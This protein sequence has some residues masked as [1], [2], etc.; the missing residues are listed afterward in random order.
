MKKKLFLISTILVMIGGVL[1]CGAKESNVQQTEVAIEETATTEENTAENNTENE[2]VNEDKKDENADVAQE[3]ENEEPVIEETEVPAPTKYMSKEGIVD[4]E[5]GVIIKKDST[6]W[7]EIGFHGETQFE[8]GDIIDHVYF[9]CF[10]YNGDI[11]SYISEHEGLKKGM[12]DNIE[13]AAPD[14]SYDGFPNITFV[15]NGIVLNFHMT[16][17]TVKKIWKKGL[18]ICEKENEEYLVYMMEDG[19]YCPALGLEITGSLKHFDEYLFLYEKIIIR[20]NSS[21]EEIFGGIYIYLNGEKDAFLDSKEPIEVVEDWFSGL[22]DIVL[23]GPE[24][25]TYGKYQFEGKGYTHEYG[26]KDW[27][28][29][30]EETNH[31]INVHCSEAGEI[32][33]FSSFIEEL[34]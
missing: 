3:Q 5:L 4:E 12:L 28:Y 23:E 18:N 26:K 9:T 13:Y 21:K 7:D 31:L 34:K 30:S 15:K 1:G 16:E 10:Y 6:D 32:E 2:T 8:Y 22:G 14:D 17:E 29:A 11:D 19:L 20:A 25:K 33:Y 24:E 27:R